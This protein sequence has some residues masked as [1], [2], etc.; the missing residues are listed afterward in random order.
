MWLIVGSV[1]APNSL[2]QRGLGSSK[3]TICKREGKDAHSKIV[4]KSTKKY[5]QRK[6]LEKYHI[7]NFQVYNTFFL[8][9]E[10]KSLITNQKRYSM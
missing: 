3:F 1:I 9:K 4:W 8:K 5:V 10:K 2:Q 6:V 7:L